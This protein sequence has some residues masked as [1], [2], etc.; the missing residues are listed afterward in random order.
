METQ[1]R[2]IQLYNDV[3]DTQGNIKLCGREKCIDLIME[4]KKV[5]GAGY[6]GDV[7]TGIM[8]VDNIKKLVSRL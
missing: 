7:T 2:L 3:F 8:Q 1:E 5:D 4:S 6:Y